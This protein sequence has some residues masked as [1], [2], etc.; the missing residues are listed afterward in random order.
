[1]KEKQTQEEYLVGIVVQYRRILF[2][3]ACHRC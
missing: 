1:M 3:V 2:D